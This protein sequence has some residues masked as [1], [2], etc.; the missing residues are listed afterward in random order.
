MRRFTTGLLL[1]SSL[2]YVGSA[3][4]APSEA[5]RL[6]TEGRAAMT[7]NDYD[8]ACTKFAESLKLEEAPGTTLNLGDCEEKRGHLVAA[9]G[10]FRKAASGFTNPEKQKFATEQADRLEQRVP[11]FV[12][13]GSGI[14][15]LVVHEGAT[16]V[17]LETPIKHDAGEITLRAE[18]PGRK[19]KDLKGTLTEKNQITI[20]VGDLEPDAPQA[21]T[22]IVAPKPASGGMS[23]LSAVGIIVGAVG[24]ASLATGA[25]TGVMALGRASTVKDHCD[26]ALACDPQGVDAA[27]SGNTLSTVST[28]TVIA[29]AVLAVGGGAMFVLGRKKKETATTILP[30][31]S[32]AFAGVFIGRRF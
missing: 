24:V 22:T 25:V 3:H 11:K 32:P 6:F 12:V 9:E 13:H 8:T 18:A 20:D 10:Y 27:S 19:P 16:E 31:A 23:T 29:G 5:Q 7:K 17:A 21:T 26:D 14:A 30:S 28:I 4:A 15:G 1:T 2:L